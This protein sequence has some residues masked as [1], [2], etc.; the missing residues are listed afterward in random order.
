MPLKN[1]YYTIPSD[2]RELQHDE[3]ARGIGA[4]YTIPSDNRE[5]QRIGARGGGSSDYTIPSDNREL[6]PAPL[7]HFMILYYTI[8][9]DN[10]ELQRRHEKPVYTLI[11]PY[12]V[13]T[14]NYNGSVPA[15]I[16]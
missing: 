9:S 5:L 4:N 8:P 7:F 13:I 1:Y 10:R 6:Q 12:Q 2:N 11:I 14:G 16:L 3:T 15:K